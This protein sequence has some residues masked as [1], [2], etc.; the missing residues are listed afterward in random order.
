IKHE[1]SLHYQCH[2][3]TGM[4]DIVIERARFR[5]DDN[6]Q[7]YLLA[8]SS[9]FTDDWLPLV[10]RL[11]VG[12]GTRPAGVACT[13]AVFAQP[14]GVMHVA[15]V[16]VADTAESRGLLFDVLICARTDYQQFLGDPFALA[17]QAA[18]TREGEGPLHTLLL[19]RQPA[20]PRTIAQV[21]AV[22]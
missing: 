2:N 6:G 17:R 11:L 1:R 19:P 4:S 9:G 22:L 20:A 14:L 15:V 8:R 5:R 12:F 7:P 21:Q 18:S 3:I 16:Q 13:A 10:E